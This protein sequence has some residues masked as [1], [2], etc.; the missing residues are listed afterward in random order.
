MELFLSNQQ[1]IF[2]PNILVSQSVIKRFGIKVT[3]RS[4]LSDPKYLEPETEPCIYKQNINKRS[5]SNYVQFTATDLIKIVE[6]TGKQLLGNENLNNVHL[7]LD[8][9][10]SRGYDWKLLDQWAA[11]SRSTIWM[12][13][14]GGNVSS[15]KEDCSLETFTEQKLS[16]VLRNS[17]LIC[18]LANDVRKYLL[19]YERLF[20]DGFLHNRFP[21]NNNYGHESVASQNDEQEKKKKT[22]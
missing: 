2:L 3:S 14:N 12:G 18:Q 22:E 16:L 9:V 6:H 20:P 4:V 5:E 21:E 10:S 7:F 11:T 1:L 19:L 8:E 17:R 13:I 15:S